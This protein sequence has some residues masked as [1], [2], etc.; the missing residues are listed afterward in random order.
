MANQHDRFPCFR[1]CTAPE[2]AHLD[3]GIEWFY[4]VTKAHL[5]VHLQGTTRDTW[6]NNEGGSG[7]A[8]PVRYTRVQQCTA[9]PNATT[10]IAYATPS[11]KTVV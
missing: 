8:P 6:T 10:A 3:T 9:G 1:L 4:A 2:R 5:K 7:F 11:T